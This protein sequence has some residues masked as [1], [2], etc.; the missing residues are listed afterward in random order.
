M[1]H[2]FYNKNTNTVK[3]TFATAY[4]KMIFIVKK[5]IHNKNNFCSKNVTIIFKNN[6][7]GKYRKDNFS[8]K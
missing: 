2:N 8:L 6:F 1:A 3:I 5:N 7:Y 4:R